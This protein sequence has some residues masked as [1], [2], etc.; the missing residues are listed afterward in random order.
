M[1]K[2]SEGRK[3]L[4]KVIRMLKTASVFIICN[5]EQWTCG[6]A[7]AKTGQRWHRELQH[8]RHLWLPC[9][10]LWKEWFPTGLQLNHLSFPCIGH[11]QQK[12]RSW[13]ISIQIS[14]GWTRELY[15]MRLLSESL[16]TDT[17]NV[18]GRILKGHSFISIFEPMPCMLKR[19]AHFFVLLH[20]LLYLNAWRFPRARRSVPNKTLW[21]HQCGQN[22]HKSK[23]NDDNLEE[24]LRIMDQPNVKQSS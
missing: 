11:L 6:L 9:M 1:I 7:E 2:P 13:T 16:Q 21:Q 17:L 18:S 22:Y 10:R 15:L 20:K 12:S 5:H 4:S 14:F 19:L 8:L 23:T 3:I 24:A